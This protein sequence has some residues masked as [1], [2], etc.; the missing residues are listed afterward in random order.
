MGGRK[1]T[2]QKPKDNNRP[3]RSPVVLMAF[4]YP[5]KQRRKSCGSRKGGCDEKNF[6][7]KRNAGRGGP[8]TGMTKVRKERYSH[9]R[10]V[11]EKAG[12][13]PSER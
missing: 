10:G 4:D 8:K 3:V 5:N 13:T 11:K 7:K 1:R 12:A 2:E 6:V 9:H